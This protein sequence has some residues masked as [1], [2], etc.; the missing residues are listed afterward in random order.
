MSTI[1]HLLME[2][3]Y[4]TLNFTLYPILDTRFLHFTSSLSLIFSGSFK[5]GTKKVQNKI[6]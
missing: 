3:G 6:P 5:G 1:L 4:V 2:K